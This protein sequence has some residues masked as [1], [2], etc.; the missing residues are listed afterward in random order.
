MKNWLRSQHFNNHEELMEGAVTWLTSQ[1]ADFFDIG[2]KTLIPRH[3]ECLS[4]EGDYVEK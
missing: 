2:I 3:N 4:S 1:A